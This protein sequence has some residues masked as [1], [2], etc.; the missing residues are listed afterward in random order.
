MTSGDDAEHARSLTSLGYALKARFTRTG[1]DPDL[2]EAVESGRRALVHD[3]GNALF[4]VSVS[5]TLRI[6]F[7]QHGAEP[8]LDE[9]ID[10]GRRATGLMSPDSDRRAD[11][12]ANLSGLL[13]ARV[14]L[15][16]YSGDIDE[17][18]DAARQAVLAAGDEDFDRPKLLLT[19]ARALE[20]RVRA[21]GRRR[22]SRGETGPETDIEADIEADRSEALR[23]LEDL[24]GCATAAPRIRVEGAKMGAWLAVENRAPGTEELATRRR[25]AGNRGSPGAGDRATPHAPPRTAGRHPV[26][27]RTG[28]QRRGTGAARPGPPGGATRRA[29]T[30]VAG[31][32]T[33]GALEPTPGHPRRPDRSPT[34]PPRPG[35]TVHRAAGAARSGRR[36]SHPRGRGPHRSGRGVDRDAARDPGGWTGSPPSPFLRPQPSCVPRPTRARSS[37]S[38]SRTAATR[39]CSPRT[40]SPHCRCRA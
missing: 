29:C 11:A 31:S 7:E 35:D 23:V 14:D 32:G 24:V 37:R 27:H 15:H 25:P 5:D 18:V 19:L 22:D 39:S 40:T 26:G 34:G 1:N 36:P 9:A 16:P 12:F 4:L 30:V 28:R 3:A 10:L 21:A 6:R 38:T 20:V 2:D 33:C 17:A 8:D 13:R